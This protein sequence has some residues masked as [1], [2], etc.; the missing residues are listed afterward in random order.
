MFMSP[1]GQAK[2]ASDPET[3]AYMQDPQ[4]MQMLQMCQQNPQMINM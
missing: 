1:E 2:L 3:A 4:F